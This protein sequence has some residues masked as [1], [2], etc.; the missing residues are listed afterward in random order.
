MVFPRTALFLNLKKSL[1]KSFYVFFLKFV[2]ISIYVFNQAFGLNLIILCIFLN[3][4]PWFN[5]CFK[6]LLFKTYSSYH[7][8]LL[9]VFQFSFFQ[10]KRLNYCE[11]FIIFRIL[12]TNFKKI[13]LITFIIVAF[14]EIFHTSRNIFNLFKA[15]YRQLL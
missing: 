9:Q 1:S 15:I 2:I 10:V 3:T 6:F 8:S 7:P 4:N 13:S 12:N 5:A 14:Y 11:G